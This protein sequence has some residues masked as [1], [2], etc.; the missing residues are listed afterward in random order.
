MLSA[1]VSVCAEEYRRLRIGPVAERSAPPPLWRAPGVRGGWGRSYRRKSLRSLRNKSIANFAAC[2]ACR[3]S[4][5][6]FDSFSVV[7]RCCKPRCKLAS[8][9][10]AREFELRESGQDILS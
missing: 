9:H 6:R 2:L 8:L 1:D 3:F 7:G 4:L 10:C 5:G